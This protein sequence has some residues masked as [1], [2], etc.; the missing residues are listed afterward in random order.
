MKYGVHIAL[1]ATL[2]VI[3]TLYLIREHLYDLKKQ[4]HSHA[5]WKACAQ[6]NQQCSGFTRTRPGPEISDDMVAAMVK[7][8][9]KVFGSLE[10]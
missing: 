8:E 2:L 5:R 4:D 9:E 7:P 6:H 10:E 1:T 3:F